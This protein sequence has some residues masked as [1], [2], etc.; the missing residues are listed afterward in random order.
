MFSYFLT[1]LFCASVAM[2]IPP[3]SSIINLCALLHN[4]FSILF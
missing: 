2:L 4:T 3:F 1:A